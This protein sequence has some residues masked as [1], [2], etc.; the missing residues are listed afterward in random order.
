MGPDYPG[1]QTALNVGNGG[2]AP[3]HFIQKMKQTIIDSRAPRPKK[4]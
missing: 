2:L 1:L 3:M 4:A